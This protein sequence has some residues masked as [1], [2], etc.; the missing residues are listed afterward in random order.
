[1][2]A[3]TRQSQ[4]V[5]IHAPVKGRPPVPQQQVTLDGVSIHAPVKGRRTLFWFTPCA[6]RV[7]IHAPVKGRLIRGP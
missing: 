7:S 3:I 4:G 6:L 2:A 5:S 1:M